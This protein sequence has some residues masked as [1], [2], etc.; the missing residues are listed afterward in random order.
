[1]K[2]SRRTVKVTAPRGWMRR[3]FG[4]LDER[5]V[6]TVAARLVQRGHD[7]ETVKEKV[8]TRMKDEEI[9]GR[10]GEAL[11]KQELRVEFAYPETL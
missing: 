6:G 1:M 3:A 4:Q 9:Q 10:L 2:R 11:D 8:I 7:P 5:A